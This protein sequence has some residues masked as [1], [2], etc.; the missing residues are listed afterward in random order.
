LFAKTSLKDTSLWPNMSFKRNFDSLV[1]TLSFESSDIKSPLI[2]MDQSIIKRSD[3][4]IFFF[5]GKQVFL[6]SS[7]LKNNREHRE[8]R[9]STVLS[10]DTVV[11]LMIA[12]TPE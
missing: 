1:L 11:D 12:I 2:T 9:Q 5:N 3:F 7:V 8:K 10:M 4:L 6:F